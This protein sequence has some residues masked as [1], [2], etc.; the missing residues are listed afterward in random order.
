MSKRTLRRAAERAARKSAKQ[1]I[2]PPITGKKI[3]SE[4]TLAATASAHTYDPNYVF[5][6]DPDPADSAE[7]P[8]D[9]AAINRANAQKSTGPVTSQG[10]LICSQNAV[11]HGLT[12]NTVLLDSDDTEAYQQ[13]LDAHVTQFKPVTFEERRLVQSI[14]DSAWRLDRILNHESTIYAVG[15]ME[16]QFCFGQAAEELR[17]SFIELEILERNGKKLRNLHIQE[18]RLQRQRAK[19]IAALKQLIQERNAQEKQERQAKTQEKTVAEPA[20]AAPQHPECLS[21]RPSIEPTQSDGSVLENSRTTRTAPLH[22]DPNLLREG[23][24]NH[25][26]EQ[27]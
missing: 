20:K 22:P 25:E 23:S 27:N 15:R 1:T 4:K 13:R 26:T 17:K 10:K 11:K 16:L 21:F 18:A 5:Q 19:D 7:P 12:G 24:K 14:H 8:I 6:D 3:T 2:H 9:R